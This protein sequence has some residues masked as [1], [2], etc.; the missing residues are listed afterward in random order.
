MLHYTIDDYY[1]YYLVLLENLL[2]L[3]CLTHIL[4]DVAL[5]LDNYHLI[6]HLKTN[7]V[8]DY[9]KLEKH[10]LKIENKYAVGKKKKF[11]NL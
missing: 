2:L 5:Y 3:P 6:L 10:E 4:A 9:L 7:Y 11:T 8:C 1:Y